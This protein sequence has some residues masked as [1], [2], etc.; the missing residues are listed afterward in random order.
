[1]DND[2]DFLGTITSN[3][4][5]PL[6]TVLTRNKAGQYR[7]GVS[8]HTLPVFKQNVPDHHEYWQ[9]I[10]AEIQ[11]LDT[12]KLFNKVF[13][14]QTTYAKLLQYV[15]DK[16]KFATMSDLSIDC[17]E[18]QL[19]MGLFLDSIGAIAPLELKSVA[20]L[21]GIE[22]ALDGSESFGQIFRQSLH[23]ADDTR[24]IIALVVAHTMAKA[25]CGQGYEALVPDGMYLVFDLFERPLNTSLMNC[26]AGPIS[27]L[28]IPVLLQVAFLRIKNAIDFDKIDTVAMVPGPSNPQWYNLV[29]G[30][31]V[32]RLKNFAAKI[33][34]GRLMSQIA[35][36]QSEEII[37]ASI[38]QLH[39]LYQKNASSLSAQEDLKTIFHS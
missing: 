21:L 6:V 35:V 18:Q 13:R 8:L 34:L 27:E 36:T 26:N 16:T 32:Y 1:M 9:F 7:Q 33:L 5:H 29:T 19:Y 37:R 23:L 24:A 14:K 20:P 10:A 28:L 31:K 22:N 3:D 4:L 39:N 30:R 38:L 12:G 25:A 15:L 17:M 11:R 2:L